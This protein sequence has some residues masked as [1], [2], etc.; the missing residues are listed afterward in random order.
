[1]SLI[2]FRLR[3][4][5]SCTGGYIDMRKSRRLGVRAMYDS[6]DLERKAKPTRK[7]AWLGSW[8]WRVS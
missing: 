4:A 7:E 8:V 3:T 5:F 2:L 1:M 6:R